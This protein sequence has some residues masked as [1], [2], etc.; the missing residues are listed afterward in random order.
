MGEKDILEKT[1]EA[2][3]DVF[4]DIVNGLFFN[5]GAWRDNGTTPPAVQ[6]GFNGDTKVR[7]NNTLA[8]D[9]NIFKTGDNTTNALANAHFELYGSD[10]YESDGTTVNS[11]VNPIKTNLISSSN[12]KIAL[13]MLSKGTYYLLETQAPSGYIQ[14]SKPVKIMIDPTS[15]LNKTVAEGNNT[16]TY[17]LFVTYEYYLE[18]GNEANL[19]INHEGIA[20]QVNEEEGKVS[21]SYALTVPNTS[22]VELPS[23]GGPGTTLPYLL[24]LMLTA[25]AGLGLMMK[26]KRN[27][28]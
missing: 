16:R 18:S 28:A 8:Y 24:G 4:A 3:D 13:G 15:N 7:V 6:L 20:I 17:P 14:L 26:K 23:T 25:F 19:S 5:N 27:A 9:V 12:G 1:L 10:Y 22:G 11:G 21:Y 2:Y